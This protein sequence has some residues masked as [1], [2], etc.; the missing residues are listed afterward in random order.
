M[1]GDLN[2]NFISIPIKLVL[3]IMVSLFIG[4]GRNRDYDNYNN[5]II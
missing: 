3:E 1:V 2:F 4:D 5:M